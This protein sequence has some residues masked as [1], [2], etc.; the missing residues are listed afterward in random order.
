MKMERRGQYYLIISGNR[1]IHKSKDQSKV[2]A[3]YDHMCKVDE[4]RERRL[5]RFKENPYNLV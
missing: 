5:E 1:V 3:R 4:N 2:Q